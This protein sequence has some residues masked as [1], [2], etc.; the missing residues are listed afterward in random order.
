MEPVTPERVWKLPLGGRSKDWS[1]PKLRPAALFPVGE[2][3]AAEQ[4]VSSI[5]VATTALTAATTQRPSPRRGVV[6]VMIPLLLGGFSL[7]DPGISG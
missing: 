7:C 2:R 6:W 3:P 1:A 4:P 5:A